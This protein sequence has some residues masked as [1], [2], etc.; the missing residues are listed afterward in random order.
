M[1]FKN[2]NG[3]VLSIGHP[4]SNTASCNIVIKHLGYFRFP[5][6]C[7]QCC[8]GHLLTI[9]SKD[10][11]TLEHARLS[12]EEGQRE[13]ER[14][15]QADSVLSTQP[16]SLTW[17]SI[18]WSWAH[19][20]SQNQ[21]SVTSQ[22]EL[23]RGPHLCEHRCLPSLSDPLLVKWSWISYRGVTNHLNA[24]ALSICSA[25]PLGGRQFRLGSLLGLMAVP[26]AVGQLGSPLLGSGLWLSRAVGMT[27]PHVFILP[28]AA[29]CSSL[30]GRVPRC[31]GPCPLEA[32]SLYHICWLNRAQG[33]HR[34]KE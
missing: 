9:F 30:G 20:L 34:L 7:R 16:D 24:G 23:P 28:H 25:H 6:W 21:E 29:L 31:N 17:D 4:C 15:S 3:I 13:R 2:H 22:T 11:F 14:A 1:V 10:L 33:Q 8:L 12:R 32:R 27:G 18:S 19:N 5:C 26:S